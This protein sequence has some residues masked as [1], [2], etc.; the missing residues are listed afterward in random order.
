MD[1][2]SG[3]FKA[4]LGRTIEA[5]EANELTTKGLILSEKESKWK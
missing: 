5:D 3:S 4:K 2:K 1:K